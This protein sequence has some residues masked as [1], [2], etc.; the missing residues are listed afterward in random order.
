MNKRLYQSALICLL[1][2][3]CSD[4]TQTELNKAGE[5]CGGSEDIYIITGYAL[6]NDVVYCKDGIIEFID[7]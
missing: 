7:N 1:V 5:I 4:I 3:S 2:A 6:K